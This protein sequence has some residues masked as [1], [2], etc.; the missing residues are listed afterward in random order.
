MSVIVGI[1]AIEQDLLE[2]DNISA[3]V[4][5]LISLGNKIADNKETLEQLSDDLRNESAKGMFM[6][7]DEVGL[8][9][10]CKPEKATEYLLKKGIP[11]HKAGRGYVVNKEQFKKYFEGNNAGQ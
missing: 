6:T 5:K 7:M 9:L 10:R 8:A 1:S 3:L 11:M 4:D 2:V